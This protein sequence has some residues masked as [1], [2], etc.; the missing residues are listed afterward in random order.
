MA[1]PEVDYFVLDTLANDLE[2][3]EDILRLLNSELMGWRHR[4]PAPFTQDEVLPVLRR[5]V[6]DGLVNVAAFS[7]TDRA[8]VDLP[9]RTWPAGGL[10]EV[11]FRLTPH[12]RMVHSAWEPDLPEDIGPSRS[13]EAT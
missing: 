12:G 13:Q 6:Q 8:L 7:L 3:L 9:A 10:H 5:V 2:S 11:W 4:H 1:R